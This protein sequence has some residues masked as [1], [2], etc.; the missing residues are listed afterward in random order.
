MITFLNTI[1]PHSHVLFYPLRDGEPCNL[2]ILAPDTSSDLDD[3]SKANLSEI[4]ELMKDWDPRF[5]KLLGMV[6][7]TSK[8]ML[9]D[10]VELEHW[11]SEQ[12]TFTMIG[13]ACHAT[14]PYLY[15]GSIV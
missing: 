3:S 1:G 14:I 5:Q 11:T 4:K 15:V 2:V 9:Q 6:N 13:D 8:W 12:G 7:S 10:N